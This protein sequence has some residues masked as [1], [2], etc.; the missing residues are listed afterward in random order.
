MST[1][2]LEYVTNTITIY[3]GIFLLITGTI[4]NSLNLIV[5][6]SLK[7]FR[8]NPCAFYLTVMSAM[9]IGQLL[10]GLLS[11]I[12]IVGFRIDWTQTSLFFCKFRLFSFPTT[13]L[14]SFS[15][16]CLATI[17]Q[18]LAT[19]TRPRWQQ[20]SNIKLAHRITGFF[21]LFWLCHGI[22]YWIEI[23][24]ISTPNQKSIVCAA[25]SPAFIHYHLYFVSLLLNGF[26][27]V[28][29]T[30]IFGLLAYNNVRTMSYRTVPLVRRELEKQ[31]TIMVLVQVVLN[32]LTVL[33]F[34][35]INAIAL[36]PFINNNSNTR[37]IFRVVTSYSVL[38]NYSYFAVSLLFMRSSTPIT[39]MFIY[40]QSPFFIYIAASERFRRQ[41][42]YVLTEILWNRR[43]RNRVAPAQIALD[44]INSTER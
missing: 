19:C 9:N 28:L 38:L 23:N 1:S 37:F 20:W 30:F 27:P 32:I 24:Q 8:E 3:V 41:L 7:T 39:F 14:I 11:R 4:G 17:D 12:L 25:I 33:P 15:C 29:M 2:H 13:S 18:F 21:T 42:I 43:Q 44:E 40:F 6:L 26:L 22:F 16:I 10:T 34:S 31:L 5:F 35:V 36:N